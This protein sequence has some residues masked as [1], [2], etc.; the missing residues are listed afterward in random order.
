MEAKDVQHIRNLVSHNG[1]R[2]GS[3]M[4]R[5]ITVVPKQANDRPACSICGDTG[6]KTVQNGTNRSVTR[7]DCR[8]VSRIN[9]LIEQAKF[10][11]RYENC[12]LAGYEAGAQS[13]LAA[14]MMTAQK[15]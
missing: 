7:C 8:Q 2:V 9:Y 10:P 1:D 12:D 11:L 15:F 6:W 4:P 5:N 13:S 3:A 14:A